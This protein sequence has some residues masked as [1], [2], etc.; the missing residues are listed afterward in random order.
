MIE[1]VT[2][3]IKKIAD[4]LNKFELSTR[5]RL[6]KLNERL[7]TLERQ[8]EYLEAAAKSVAE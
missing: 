2:V 5:Y 3:N 1:N 7:S 8:M 4:F 6:A